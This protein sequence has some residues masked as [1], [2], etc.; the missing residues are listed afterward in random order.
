MPLEI[1]IPDDDL[2]GFSDEARDHVKAATVEY[3]TDLIEEA[4]RIEAGR[5]STG[6]PPEVTRG[7]VHDAGVLLRRGL[8]TPRKSWGLR[9]LRVISAVLSLFVGIMYDAEKLQSGGYMLMFILAVAATILAVTIS[10]LK[11]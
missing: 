9:I 10:T 5:N 6:G 1:Q 3:V 11:E 7:M 2:K 8:G 4:N